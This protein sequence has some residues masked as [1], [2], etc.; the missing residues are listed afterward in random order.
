MMLPLEQIKEK[1]VQDGKISA[2]ELQQKIQTKMT[3][4]SGLISEEG[5]A[6]IIANE[7]GVEL[8]AA[9]S[10][11][12]M[13]SLAAG[14]RNV[15]TVGKVTQKYDVREFQS[16]RGPGK[17]GSFVIADDTGSIRVVLWNDQAE[18]L[19]TFK[20]NDTLKISS[21][22]VRDNRGRIELHLNE[23][24]GIEV[25]PDGVVIENVVTTL[26]QAEAER[27]K[28]ADLTELDLNVELL[29]T[30]VDVYDPRYFAL[31][32][33]CNKRVGENDGIFSCL[34]HG[35]VTPQVSF[36]VNALG[37]DGSD[38]IRLVFWR[39]QTETLLS[40]DNAAVLRFKDF[41][42]EFQD[43]KHKLLGEIVKVHGK[44]RKN[45]MFDRLE[46]TAQKVFL[47]PNPQEE[48]KKLQ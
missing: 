17:V 38:T 35:A 23:R 13:S 7:L 29:V 18:K 14:L 19:N 20:Q 24:S 16:A 2:D 33:Q 45:D 28:I 47:K 27:K 1:I 8:V 9:S 21:G 40:L 41:P 31:C 36:V 15:E 39:E 34:E 42:E 11:M 25:N 44:V 4:L 10:T 48:M 43:V 46:F 22:Y 30:L 12:K 37:D 3:E 26:Q 6:H 32:P 5:A